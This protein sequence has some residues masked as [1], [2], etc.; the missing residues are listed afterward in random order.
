[1]NGMVDKADD[2]YQRYAELDFSKAKSVVEIPALSQLQAEAVGRGYDC[3]DTGGRAT[4]GQ[5]LSDSV[6]GQIAKDSN[7]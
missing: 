2:F 1:M 4:Q 5:L 6:T 3:K 7:K